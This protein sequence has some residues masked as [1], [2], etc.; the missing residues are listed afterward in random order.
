MLEDVII[1][2]R[3]LKIQYIW[4]DSMCIVQDSDEKWCTESRRMSYYEN[5]YI[6][7]IPVLCHSADQGFLGHRPRLITKHISG[8]WASRPEKALHFYYAQRESVRHEAADSCWK[9][10]GWTFQK[11]LL[12]TRILYFGRN[13]VRFEGRGAIFEEMNLRRSAQDDYRVFFASPNHQSS[14]WNEME[15]FRL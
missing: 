12:S 1:V 8:T 3:R 5:S 6:M 14:K 10:R 7:I 13:S 11:R 2:A 15:K 9:T 4:I